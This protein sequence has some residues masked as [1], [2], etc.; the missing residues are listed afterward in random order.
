[1]KSAAESRRQQNAEW[2]LQV[3]EEK[4]GL[5]RMTRLGERGNGGAGSVR[6]IKSVKSCAGAS[7]SSIWRGFCG[8]GIFPGCVLLFK[9]ILKEYARPHFFCLFFSLYL[10]VKVSHFIAKKEK[11]ILSAL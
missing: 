2:L 5:L 6:Q 10:I 1:M 7:G 8:G 4:P 3:T 9:H 11:G